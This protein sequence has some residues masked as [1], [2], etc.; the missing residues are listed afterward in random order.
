MN[1]FI[2]TLYCKYFSAWYFTTRRVHRQINELDGKI[3][4]EQLTSR[5]VSCKPRIKYPFV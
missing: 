2:M 3:P 1:L 5:Q 4:D